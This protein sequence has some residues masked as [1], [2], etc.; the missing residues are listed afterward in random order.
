MNRNELATQIFRE[1]GIIQERV[2]AIL[3]NNLPSDLPPAQFKLLNHLMY[4]TNRD[5]TAS[6][7]AKNSHISLSAMSQIIKQLLKKQYIRLDIR[8][9]DAR[10]KTITITEQGRQIH[11]QSLENLSPKTKHFASLL[12]LA[13]AQHLFESLRHFRQLFEEQ[14]DTF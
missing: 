4:T 9:Y 12:K 1:I 2:D 6:D 14:S 3:K 5:E 10:K 8:D 11:Q 7:L 13:D